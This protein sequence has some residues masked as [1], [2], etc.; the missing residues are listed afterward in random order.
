MPAPFV[1]ACSYPVRTTSDLR[2]FVDGEEAFAQ[3]AA[4][5]EAAERCV[6]VTCAYASLN[7]RMRPPS[8]EQLLDLCRRISERGVTVALLF[9]KP[10]GTVDGTV[11]DSAAAQIAREA[12]RV[13]CRW[14]VANT[15]GIYPKLLGCHHQKTFVVDGK[16]AFV[17]G[18][19]MTQDYWDTCAH[20]SG[21][22]RRVSY[23][24]V[25]PAE[26]ARRAAQALPLHDLFSRFV[27][28]AVADVEANFVERYNGATVRSGPDLPVGSPPVGDGSGTRLQVL[29]TIA[30]HTYAGCSAGEES[31]KAGMLN[32]IGAAQSS[33][34]F[35]N[36]YFFDDDVVS[37]LR[38]AGERGVRVVGL[39]TRKPDA[40]QLVGHLESLLE[41]GE[42]SR[43]QWTGFNPILK[44]RIQLY[45]PYTSDG[46]TQKDIYVHSK[47][48]I[49]D[50]RWVITGSANIS[51]TS[52]DFHSEMSILVEHE[53]QARALRMRLWAEHLCSAPAQLPA[54]F[55]AGADLWKSAGDRN[56]LLL[57]KAQL[58][59]RVVPLQPDPAS[60]PTLLVTGTGDDD[61][62]L[63]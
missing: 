33:I 15:S 41:D 34:Y 36:Q 9:W 62:S 61:V 45:T 43:F 50:D 58:P 60:T 7:F 17:G 37:A 2:F 25:D 38:A 53:A 31:I 24:V 26:R 27:G 14:D 32:A 30:P 55:E 12:P 22:D 63:T 42:E 44:Q 48:M 19:N 23:D 6:Y 18:I 57:G 35:E 47:T 3:I 4:A 46:A 5:V 51:F 56:L 28:P 54:D 16:V 21:D 1:D 13:L 29:R 8:G 11:P 59:T 10:T 20:A 52:L 40:G 39:L 49:V